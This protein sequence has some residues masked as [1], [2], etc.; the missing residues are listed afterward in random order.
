MYIQK[1]A[2][3]KMMKVNIEVSQNYV[4]TDEVRDE[5]ENKEYKKL[6]EDIQSRSNTHT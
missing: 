1:A 4:P 2:K 5:Q 3:I 6:K